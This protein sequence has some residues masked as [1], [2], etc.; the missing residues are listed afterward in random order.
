MIYSGD[1][2][3]FS[4][5]GFH[6]LKFSTDQWYFHCKLGSFFRPSEEAT[7]DQAGSSADSPAGISDNLPEA[8]EDEEIQKAFEFWM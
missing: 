4:G 6:C 8:G 3:Q 5:G 1:L 7:V 2:A